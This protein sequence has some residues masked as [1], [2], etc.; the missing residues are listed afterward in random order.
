MS[1]IYSFLILVNSTIFQGTVVL[2]NNFSISHN[3]FL[4]L[5]YV[6]V[7]AS[8]WYY[9]YDS[10]LFHG[11]SEFNQIFIYLYLL[12]V[13]FICIFYHLYH[14]WLYIHPI[15][16]SGDIKNFLSNF[17][18]LSYL[19]SVNVHSYAKVSLLKAY[20][21]IQKFDI[22]CLLETYLDLSVL[23][24]SKIKSCLGHF[25]AQPQKRKKILSEKISYV[26]SIKVPLIFQEMEFSSTK[27]KIFLIFSQKAF[28]IF[29]QME[30][31]KKIPYISGGNFLSSK[32]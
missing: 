3:N 1:I 18:C 5:L 25:S 9:F 14:I 21:S 20:L 28:L 17:F 12:S 27:Y 30:L 16:L 15:D 26:F 22:I 10:F 29:Q 8:D 7:A 11:N 6:S 2:F 24:S 23:L 32:H 19:N 31:L 4:Y 13:S